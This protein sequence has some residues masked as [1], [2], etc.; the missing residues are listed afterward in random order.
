MLLQADQAPLTSAELAT[1]TEALAVLSNGLAAAERASLLEPN[2]SAAAWEATQMAELLSSTQYPLGPGSLRLDGS[3]CIQTEQ[4]VAPQ[5]DGA[6][7]CNGREDLL[8]DA[9]HRAVQ[10]SLIQVA[11][12]LSASVAGEEARAWCLKQLQDTRY[13]PKT[14]CAILGPEGDA[15]QFQAEVPRCNH[16]LRE[17]HESCTKGACVEFY[18]SELLGCRGGGA[19]FSQEL[20]ARREG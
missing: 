6:N 12:A 18:S 11:T 14:V 16:E 2:A 4:D 19:C 15:M 17:C 9:H 13:G 10:D 7:H 20:T 8:G 1:L 3:T 5:Q